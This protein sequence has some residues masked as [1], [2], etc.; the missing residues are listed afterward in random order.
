MAG[1]VLE[2]ELTLP[3]AGKV[4]F[5]VARQ[6]DDAEI[7][8][9]LRENAM[10]GQIS[11]SLEREPNYFADV[12][13][14]GER[15]Q[16]II[17]REKGRLICV[18]SCCIRK[19]F[20][21]GMPRDVGYLGGL[22]LDAPFAGR[23]DILRRGYEFFR[24]TQT[25]APADFYFTSIASDNERARRVLERGMTGMPT[26]EFLG[27]FVTALIPVI[28]TNAEANDACAAPAAV[29]TEFINA[30][31]QMRQF[32]PCWTD[33]ELQAMGQLGLQR[34]E[35][36]TLR[37]D[38]RIVG[39][40]AIWDQRCF[41]Q[42]VIRGYAP[43]LTLARPAVNALGPILHRPQL[44]QVGEV[45]SNA[46]ACHLAV[47]PERPDSLISLVRLLEKVAASRGVQLL[48]LGFAGNDSRLSAIRSH[49]RSREY[50]SRIYAVRW[51]G[52][53][54]DARELDGRVLGP[55]VALL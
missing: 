34:S 49:F 16:T 11:I 41:K 53:G 36:V 14:P 35:F 8:R 26:Y 21:N 44:P 31:N 51:P 25:D 9:L 38:G 29:L 37:D 45:L 15:K 3:R 47:R 10:P 40:G 19:R 4:E 5:S 12:N 7:R 22:R 43:W 6:A 13:L 18:G 20:V 17:A 46:F 33:E 1:A 50:R 24:K 42:T 32:S 48:T 54:G 2:R 28:R 55:E 27:E 39:C 30:E 52:I 23:F